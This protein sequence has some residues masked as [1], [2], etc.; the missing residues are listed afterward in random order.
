MNTTSSPK[1]IS[2]REHKQIEHA[3]A[4]E[5][6]PVVF[7]HGLWLLPSSWGPWVAL[8]EEAGYAAL[9]PDWPYDPDTVEQARREPAG[10]RQEDLEAGRRSHDRGHQG[11]GQEAG[12]HGSFHWGFAGGDA[13][14][15]GPFGSHGGDRPW[16]LPRR[17]AAA[18]LRAQGRRPVSAQPGHRGR[19]ITLT[20]DQFKYGWANALTRRRPRSSTTSSMSPAPGSPSCRWA[21]RISTRGP[22]RRSTRRTPTVVRC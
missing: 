8:F 1:Q 5:A 9:T 4:I 12:G 10:S 6:T 16:R 14:G 11:P 17:P 7:I 22:N 15:P 13:R 21:T 3:N 2:Q 18:V 19:A 20:F